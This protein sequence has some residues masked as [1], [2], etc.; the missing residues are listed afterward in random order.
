MNQSK[1]IGKTIYKLTVLSGIHMINDIPYFLCSC[2]CGIVKYIRCS[3]IYNKA[4]KSCGCSKYTDRPLK[5]VEANKIFNRLTTTGNTKWMKNKKDKNVQMIECICECGTNNWFNYSRVKSGNVKSCGCLNKQHPEKRL[6]IANNK[7]GKLIVISQYMKN[8][9]TYCICRCD[10]G[11]HIHVSAHHLMRNNTKSCGCL[12]KSIRNNENYINKKFERL[13]VLEYHSGKNEQ[14]KFLCQCDCGRIKIIKSCK[15]GITQGCG[16][17][18]GLV[19]GVNCS[20]QQTNIY[21]MI[22]LMKNPEL[23]YKTNGKYIDIAIPDQ[24]IAIEYDSW[25]YHYNKQDEDRIRVNLLINEGWKVLSIKSGHK[26]PSKER[27]IYEIDR[28]YNGVDN[29]KEIVM[30]DWG[31]GSTFKSFKKK[32]VKETTAC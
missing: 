7:F 24:K 27:L 4:Q 18:C 20:K 10:C 26:I 16:E 29:Y 9:Q 15:L 23:N 17:C 1:Y 11:S 8:T 2:A 22:P 31:K 14:K 5:I 6:Q 28:L 19:N 12:R 21:K 13:L 32:K 30:E 25:C 3:D